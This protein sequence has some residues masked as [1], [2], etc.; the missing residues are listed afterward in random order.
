MT[1]ALDVKAVLACDDVR[2]EDNGKVFVIGMYLGNILMATMP[3]DISLTFLIQAH[4][5]RRP[6][7]KVEFRVSLKK[8]N[9]NLMEP[10]LVTLDIRAEGALQTL[11]IKGVA[12]KITEQCSVIL[13]M[14]SSDTDS[15]MTISTTAVDL[16]SKN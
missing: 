5:Q 11:V 7:F 6:P 12:L 16:Q 14:K 2:R 10:R 4:A 8:G 13:E 3:S 15:W 9:Q 1:F